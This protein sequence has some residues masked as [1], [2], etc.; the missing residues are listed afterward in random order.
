MTS[1]APAPSFPALPPPAAGMGRRPNQHRNDAIARGETHYEGKPC[2]RCGCTTRHVSNW[3][4][5]QCNQL[6][7][8]LKRGAVYKGA[9]CGK[10]HDGLRYARNDQ[11]VQCK[12]DA[13]ARQVER[14]HQLQQQPQLRV[15]VSEQLATLRAERTARQRRAMGLLA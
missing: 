11:C 2:H 9:P 4:C 13:S 1:A 14:R 15:P 7:D 5:V 12:R 10:G 6:T 3:T 8:Q